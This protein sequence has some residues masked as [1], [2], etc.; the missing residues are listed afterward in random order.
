[1]PHQLTD[2]FRSAD[3]FDGNRVHAMVVYCSDG[4]FADQCDDFLHHGLQL[5]RYD[6]LALPGGPAC[7]SGSFAGLRD[8]Q[9][10]LE[11]LRFLVASHGLQQ[12]VL[13]AH[14]DCGFYARHLH[15]SAEQ[16]ALQ[17]RD[18]LRKAGRRVASLFEG[19]QV[20]LYF[21]HQTPDGQIEMEPLSP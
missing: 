6:R 11:Q 8:E 15:L 2:T 3:R 20:D 21:A 16:V 7:L 5:P 19:L 18:D 4:R 14:D 9:T 17:Q 1:M 10:L 12:V 13:I